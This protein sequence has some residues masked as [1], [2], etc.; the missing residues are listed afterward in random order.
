MQL[1]MLLLLGVVGLLGC[2][3]KFEPGGGGVSVGGQAF[4]PTSC[5]VNAVRGGIDLF[6]AE[7]AQLAA[8]MPPQQ[9][10]AFSDLAGTVDV[11]VT[12]RGAAEQDLGTCGTLALTGE[13]YHGDG[14]RAARGK[15]VLACS[16]A[17]GEL[18]FSGCF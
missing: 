12:R 11:R 6:S 4:Q 9:L 14:K 1:R 15:L 10:D 18:T 13:G 2:K 17:Q 5:H 7:G 16:Q 8:V 3:P